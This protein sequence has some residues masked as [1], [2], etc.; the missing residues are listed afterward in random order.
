MANLLID[1]GNS[2]CK[3]AFENGGKLGEIHRS[4]GEDVLSFILSLTGE[5]KYNVIVLSTVR[6]DDVAMQDALSKRCQRL[7]VVKSGMQLP[8]EFKYGFPAKGLGADRLAAALAVAMLFPGRDC[9]KF[10]FG[11]ALTVDFITKDNVFAGGNIS[12]GMQSR[13]RALNTFTKRLPL[14]RPEGELQDYGTD[15]I[16]AMTSGVV[17]GMIFEVEGYLKKYPNH[18]VVFTGGDSFYFAEKLKNSIFVIPN[19]VL[20]GLALIADYYAQQEICN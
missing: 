5:C 19:L 12:L 20:V 7:V 11:T 17:L 10:D 8:V 2:N 15:T 9:I 14:I 6:E 1:I 4:A 13:F 3:A 16:S 18:T